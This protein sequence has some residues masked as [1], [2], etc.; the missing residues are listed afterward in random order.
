MAEGFCGRV[1]HAG[2]L[3]RA[4]ARAADAAAGRRHSR[5]LTSP[6]GI[7]CAI[8]RAW[9]RGETVL[10]H[11]A[12]GGVGGAAIQLAQR[13]G[14]TVIATAGTKEKR[15]YL[16]QLGVEHVFDS[17]SLD[18]YN[19]VMEVTGGRGVD[20]VLN[21]LTGRFIAQ[22]LKCLAPFGR[23]IET[24][25]VGHLSQQQAEPGAAG[26]EHLLLRRRCR[27]ARR[28]RSPSCTGR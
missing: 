15:D 16:R 13:A 23:F 27:S 19:Q 10:I 12:A 14:A 18:F 22:S 1:D 9:L 28:C 7:R 5:R 20:I 21:S 25:Q 6:P 4:P 17:R 3:R 11:S 24:R 2:P 8:W 26:R